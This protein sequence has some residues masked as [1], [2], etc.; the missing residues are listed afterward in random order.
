MSMMR[1]D[2]LRVLWLALVLTFLSP[3]CKSTPDTP[4]TR[5]ASVVIAHHP[6]AE[7]EAATEKVFKDQGY[8]VARHKFGEF[9]FEKEGT[10]MNTL[11]YGDWSPKKVWVRVKLFLRELPPAQEILVECDV[12]MVGEHGDARF[13]EEHKLTHLHRSRY[14]EVLDQIGQNL[15]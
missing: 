13:E 7:V 3:G 4:S 5:L 6:M 11:V 15:K 8:A 1:P 10:S 2:S 12:Y 9:V 14:Q